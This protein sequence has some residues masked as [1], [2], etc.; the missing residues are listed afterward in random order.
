MGELVWLRVAKVQAVMRRIS[1]D[2]AV[3][4]YGYIHLSGLLKAQVFQLSKL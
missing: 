4:Q 3:P 2:A 1:E